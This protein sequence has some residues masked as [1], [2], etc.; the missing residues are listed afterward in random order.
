VPIAVLCS[1]RA[2]LRISQPVAEILL[3]GC[4]DLARRL[5]TALN[6]TLLGLDALIGILVLRRRW[7]QA[8]AVQAAGLDGLADPV[9]R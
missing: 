3:G 6:W 9:T 1:S 4:D 7:R 5:L 2:D 8:R